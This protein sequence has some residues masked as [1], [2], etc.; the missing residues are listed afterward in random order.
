MTESTVEIL[1]SEDARKWL[2][3]NY[4][5]SVYDAE[6]FAEDQDWGGFAFILTGDGGPLPIPSTYVTGHE[7]SQLLDESNAAQAQQLLAA[8]AIPLKDVE[9]VFAEFAGCLAYDYANE[10]VRIVADTIGNRLCDY[11]VLNDEDFGE[12]E[13]EAAI[14][15]LR[16][17]Y[18]MSEEL[19]GELLTKLHDMGHGDAEVFCG[20]CGTIRAHEDVP[21]AMSAIGYHKCADCDEWLKTDIE[22]PL[23]YDCAPL[24]RWF[25]DCDCIANL[26]NSAKKFDCIVAV[27]EINATQLACEHCYAKAHEWANHA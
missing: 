18:G 3:Q 19:A 27:W 7:C 17:A 11:P 22:K 14:R 20:S 24:R 26:V 16:E 1:V 9:G 15:H 25:D 23:C 13:S 2:D 8:A 21:A 10:R 5:Y 4:R 6:E 12:R